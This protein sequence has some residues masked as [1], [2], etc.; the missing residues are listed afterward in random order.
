[1]A[2]LV[3]VAALRSPNLLRVAILFP[4]LS[5]P[6]DRHSTG[7]NCVLEGAVIGVPH[8]RCVGSLTPPREP[9]RLDLLRDGPPLRGASLRQRIRRLRAA[10]AYRF[11][12]RW[13][14]Y[15]LDFRVDRGPDPTPSRSNVGSAV[16]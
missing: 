15:G 3:S 2:G 11:A 6:G 5:D 16:S 10:R 8:G 12:A 7:F 13:R 14:A 4:R 1:M 9:H